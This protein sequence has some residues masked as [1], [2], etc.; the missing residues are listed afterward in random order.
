MTFLKQLQQGLLDNPQ[1]SAYLFIKMWHNGDGKDL[2]L[3]KYLGMNLLEY[4]L[5]LKNMQLFIQV[6]NGTNKS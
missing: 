6:H 2:M 1:E 5:F 4:N 3:Y